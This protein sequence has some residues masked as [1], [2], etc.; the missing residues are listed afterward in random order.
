MIS[1]ATCLLAGAVALP[2][3]AA[4]HSPV[5]GLAKKCKKRKHHHKKRH[6]KRPMAL[7][8][9]IAIS[10]MSQDFGVP[11]IGG[12]TRTFIITNL[13][14]SPSGAPVPTLSQAGSD[15]SIAANGCTASLPAAASCPLDVRVATDGA[16]QVSATLTVTAI[17]GGVASASMMADIEA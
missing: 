13:G 8:A 1:L 11:Q 12:E 14:G 3:A 10:P 7:P 2:G 5:A 9:T 17:P 16:G 6:C 4:S 15:F